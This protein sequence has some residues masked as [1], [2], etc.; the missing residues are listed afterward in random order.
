MIDFIFTIDYEIYGSG[1]GSLND[2]VYEPT[3]RLKQLFQKHAARFV[4]FTE[5]AEFA[6]IEKWKS[7]PAILLVRQQIH[8]LY[9]DGFEIA[10]HLHPQWCN[11]RFE[12]GE[13]I[14]DYSEYNLCTL[15]QA[16]IVEI[17]RNALDYLRRVVGEP[18]FTPLSFRAGNW[19]FQPTRDAARI[20]G[21]QGVRIDSSVFKGGLQHMHGLDYRQARKNGSYWPFSADVNQPDSRGQWIE[22]PIHTEMVPFWRMVTAKRMS[23]SARPGATNRNLGARWSRLRDRVRWQYPLKLDFCR[24]TLQELTSMMAGIIREDQRDPES[25]RPVVAIGHS[26]DLT[27]F[28]TVDAFLTFLSANR[29]AIGTFSDIYP[30]LVTQEPGRSLSDGINTKKLEPSIV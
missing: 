24:M 30:K 18:S 20:L 1:Q 23:M 27:D 4:V 3:Q 16:R 22:V 28:D 9:K 5:V 26:K 12:R 10:L 21:E 14:L 11:A 19:L 17:V 29:I 13:W 8:D 6:Q 7:D 25:F 15:P 2:L